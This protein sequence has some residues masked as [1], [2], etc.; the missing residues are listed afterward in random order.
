MKTIITSIALAVLATTL[1]VSQSMA[2]GESN[3]QIIYGGGQVCNTSVKF[4]INKLVQTPGKDYVDNLTVNDPRYSAGQIVN[5]KIVITNTGST[6]LKNLSVV[7]TFPQHVNFSTGEGNYDSNSRKLSF[8]IG[9]LPVGQS[10]EFIITSKV[11]DEGKLPTNSGVNCLVNTARAVD[12][13]GAAAED[14]SQVCIQKNFVTAV[15][16]PE[17]FQK[18]PVK[19]IPNTGPE[20][21]PLIG[22]IPTAIAGFML[23]RKKI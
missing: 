2:S 20:M 1:F 6:E 19:N 9:S 3:C 5:F 15:P 4:T 10:R 17:V 8:T 22:L 18:V 12:A 21:L 13:S 16:T 7:D 23:R 14:S 11:D